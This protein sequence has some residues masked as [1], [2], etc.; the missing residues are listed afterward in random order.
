VLRPL[1]SLL[2]VALCAGLVSGCLFRG[3]Q[4][5]LVPGAANPAAGATVAIKAD[6]PSLTIGEEMALNVTAPA[7]AM[8][9]YTSSAPG[10]AT[11]D[12]KGVVKAINVGSTTIRAA[13]GQTAATV[14]LR[15]VTSLAPEV[16]AV[17]S[18][19]VQPGSQTVQ[20]VGSQLV[21]TAVAKDAQKAALPGIPVFWFSSNPLVATITSGGVLTV[22]GTGSTE[23]TASAGDK[24]SA[25]SVITVPGGS[26]NVNVD[27]GAI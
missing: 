26:V 18:V 21:F 5:D 23:V 16:L 15:V 20:R 13:V 4:G 10:V 7:G 6:R 2:A 12:A 25:P 11:V 19:E 27:F 3:G 24:R 1:R 14:T 8:V 17:D 22:V 9:F